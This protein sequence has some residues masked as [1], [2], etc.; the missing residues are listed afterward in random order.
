MDPEFQ[1]RL[2]KS[3]T[4][5]MFREI[6]SEMEIREGIQ[7]KQNKGTFRPTTVDFKYC[8]STDLNA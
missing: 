4:E 5:T 7:R 2:S 1:T 6:S 3:S 8:T